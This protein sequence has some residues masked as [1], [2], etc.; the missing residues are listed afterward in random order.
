VLDVG[1][2][3]E[4]TYV[5][6]HGRAHSVDMAS[7]TT[8][9]DGVVAGVAAELRG[10]LDVIEA[11][12]IDPDRVVLDPGLGFA[13]TAAQNWELLRGLGPV[14]ELGRPLLLGASRKSFL[15]SLLAAD[16]GAPRPVGEREYAHA[17]LVALLTRAWPVW[18]W[19]VHDV[20][21]VHDALAVVQ[22]IGG[23]S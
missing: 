9:P 19:R 21:A 22:E 3:S 15:G 16:G 12:G 10:R 1:A 14:V 13:K 17:A 8:Y 6:M 11:A 2:D 23:G 20:R 18:G 7:F 4:A 5:A